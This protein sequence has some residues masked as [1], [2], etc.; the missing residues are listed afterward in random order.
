[1]EAEG[2]NAGG[3]RD[4][5]LR[6][7]VFGASGGTGRAF[8]EQALERGHRPTAFVRDPGKLDLE[9]E[10]LTVAKGDML[11]P[12]TIDAAAPGHDAAVFCVGPPDEN[13]VEGTRNAVAALERAGVP[14]LLTLS[15]SGV[16]ESAAQTPFV[17]RKVILPLFFRKSY[18]CKARADEFVRQ[19]SLDYVLAR[20]PRL[21][22][23]PP[24]GYHASLDGKEG[25]RSI[26]RA[27]VAAFMLEELETPRFSR[28]APIVTGA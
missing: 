7:L 13:L 17:F 28:Q 18:G 10:R 6:I 20:P 27:D 25:K 11:E 2:S 8:V 4:R 21:T 24:A 14:R 9:H 22:D 23:A 15:A 16:A 19:S 5:S 26:P 1:M 12:A 3:G